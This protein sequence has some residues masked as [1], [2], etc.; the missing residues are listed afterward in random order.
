MNILVCEDE[1][2]LLTAL[3]FRIRKHG[4]KVVLAKNDK[5]ARKI[6]EEQDIAGAVLDAE[7]PEMN[8]ISLV[9]HIRKNISK[10]M[11]IIMIGNMADEDRI[12]KSI[13]VGANDFVTK[14]FKPN[15]LVLR[16]RRLFMNK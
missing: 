16:V 11:P 4:F 5:E 3:E 13:E 7:L 2:I 8:G 10:K 9:K 6:L 14:P 12:L 15:E 1:E